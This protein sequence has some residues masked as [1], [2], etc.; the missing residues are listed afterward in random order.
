VRLPSWQLESDVE[1]I[2]S[3]L[4]VGVSLPDSAAPPPG[5]GIEPLWD[6]G[7]LAFCAAFGRAL[8]VEA[9]PRGYIGYRALLEAMNQGDADLAWLPPVIALRASSQGS[10]VP[11][12][13]PMRGGAAW[14]WAAL[15]SREDSGIRSPENLV[16]ARAAWVDAQSASG[17]LV[18]RA[19]LRSEGIDLARAFTQEIFAGSHSNVVYQ[20]LTGSA[21]VGATFAHLDPSGTRI[22]SAGWGDSP[23]QPVALAGP[24]PSDV[25]A[26]S[27]RMP[28]NLI[29]AIQELL[30]RPLDPDLDDAAK[31]FLGAE[32]F[33]I[34]DSDHMAPLMTLLQHLDDC[35]RRWHSAFPPSM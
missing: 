5:S 17:Y 10:T 31:Q 32:G 6:P 18:I 33:V 8:G 26:A 28:V 9:V 34:A 21:D 14:F 1:Q 11:M 20:V 24:I 13:L 23:M 3:V 29:R 27:L 16:G 7:L 15:F 30:T 4:R 25:L 12:V 2:G 22:V 19:W 35:A